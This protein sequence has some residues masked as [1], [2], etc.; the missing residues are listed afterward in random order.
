MLIIRLCFLISLNSVYTFVLLCSMCAANRLHPDCVDPNP[1]KSPQ[2][3]ENGDLATIECRRPLRSPMDPSQPPSCSGGPRRAV[4]SATSTSTAAC[5]GGWRWWWWWWPTERERDP[6]RHH[7]SAGPQVTHGPMPTVLSFVGPR[8]CSVAP[9]LPRPPLPV[10]VV[11]VVVVGQTRTTLAATIEVAG[12]S[13][14]PWTDADRPRP[15]GPRRCSVAPSTSTAACWWWWWWG[16]GGS[17]EQNGDPRRTIGVLL[18]PQVTHGPM[19]TALSLGG[20]SSLFCSA[21]STSTAG[22]GGGWWWW[23]WWANRTRT[24]TRRHH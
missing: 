13:G 21:T 23:W 10:V 22:A 19:P 3:N 24:A 17:T 6:L 5:C 9:H 11:V 2:Q 18:G 8:R 4:C 16:G 15:W 14:H 7:W 20:P 12:P 1:L